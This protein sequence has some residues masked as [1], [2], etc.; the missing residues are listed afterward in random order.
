M[1]HASLA[2]DRGY[3]MAERRKTPSRRLPVAEALGEVTARLSKSKS[4]KKATI[5][6]RAT[7][8][9]GGNFRLDTDSKGAKLV[10]EPPP[11]D[12]P[13]TIEIMGD[14]RRIQAALSGDKD[15]RALFLGGGLR[16]RGDLAYFSDLAVELGL[17]KE[18]V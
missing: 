18:P 2:P 3:R 9:G 16:I 4:L 14:A 10:R 1:I 5:V 15:P 17:L 12:T 6:V 8:A 13:P 11:S 7:G